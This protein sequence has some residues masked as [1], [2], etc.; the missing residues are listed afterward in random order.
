MLHV[1]IFALYSGLFFISTQSQAQKSYSL[2]SYDEVSG[3]TQTEMN[4]S[5]KTKTLVFSHLTF[6]SL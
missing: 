1:V 6:T 2:A 3:F 5:A 4:P